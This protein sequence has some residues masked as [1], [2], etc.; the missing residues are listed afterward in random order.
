MELLGIDIGGTGIK[1]APVDLD[2]G[3]LAR[4]RHRILTPHPATPD[5]V[6]DVVSQ[7]V[8]HFDSSGPVGCTFPAPIRHGVPVMAANVDKAW[9]GTDARALF[10]RRAG[11]TFVVLNDADAAGVAEMTYGAGKGRRGVVVMVTLGTGIGTA[12]FVDGTLV[13]NTEL[14]HLE[15]RGKDA[16]TRASDRARTTKEMSWEKW[17]RNLND[18]LVAIERLLWPE[19]I[20]LGGGVSKKSEKFIHL[21]EV[22]AEIEPAALQNEAGI[23]GAA[24]AAR[25]SV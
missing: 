17:G 8:D 7:V 11:R 13:P 21:L 1:G 16:E 23:I 22:D 3:D 20:I 4:A 12:L 14:G 6:A 2:R 15:V 19:L 9:I 25:A 10:E 18:Y 24:L 5:A